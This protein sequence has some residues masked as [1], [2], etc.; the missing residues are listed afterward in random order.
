MTIPFPSCYIP[1]TVVPA[2]ALRC[3]GGRRLAVCHFVAI[4][5]VF[6]SLFHDSGFSSDAYFRH[7][8]PSSAQLNTLFKTRTSGQAPIFIP[9]TQKTELRTPS[10]GR[11]NPFSLSYGR[12]RTTV[13]THPHRRTDVSARKK[14]S[15]LSVF[16][17]CFHFQTDG[18]FRLPSVVLT[19][20]RTVP[21]T[22]RRLNA[23]S[24]EQKKAERRERRQPAFCE[25]REKGLPGH[26]SVF[27]RK[28]APSRAIRLTF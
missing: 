22:S 13:P 23:L 6:L 8:V 10:H 20:A 14:A 17:T 15:V 4:S 19:S 28:E 9:L 5:P 24:A 7:F 16:F 2:H 26:Q 11:S 3:R 21:T 12:V 25:S 27:W 1:V 18:A